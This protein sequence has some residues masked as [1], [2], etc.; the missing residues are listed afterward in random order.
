M[1]TSAAEKKSSETTTP[2]LVKIETPITPVTP[3]VPQSYTKSSDIEISQTFSA[4]AVQP[5]LQSFKST[6]DTV[7]SKSFSSKSESSSFSETKVVGGTKLTTSEYVAPEIP[8]TYY[9]STVENKVTTEIPA[10]NETESLSL[11]LQT[12]TKAE[13]ISSETEATESGIETSSITKQSSLQYFVKKMKGD[14]ESTTKEVI[15]TVP[16]NPEIYKKFEDLSKT[17]DVRVVQEV[18]QKVIHQPTKFYEEAQKPQQFF[19]EFH[20]TPEPPPEICYIPKT[21]TLK[22]EE[23][24]EKI[25]IIEEMKELP[26]SEIPRGGVKILPTPTKVERQ[27]EPPFTAT[28]QDSTTTHKYESSTHEEKRFSETKSSSSYQ[29]TEPVFRP[30]A[31]IAARAFSPK[32]SAEALEMEKLWAAPKSPEVDR[33]ISSISSYSTSEKNVYLEPTSTQSVEYLLKSSSSAY[34]TAKAPPPWEV[35]KVATPSWSVHSTL[36]KKWS[37]YETKTETTRLESS[38]ISEPVPHYIA[39]VSHTSSINEQSYEKSE[40]IDYTSSKREEYTEDR[41]VKPSE[42]IKSWPPARTREEAYKPFTPTLPSLDSLSIRPISVQDITDEIYLEPGPPPEIG[43]AEPPLM[44][45]QSQVEIIEQDL[46]KNLEREPTK[47]LPGAVRTMPPPKERYVPPPLPPKREFQQPP[48]LP[49]KPSKRVEQPKKVVEIPSQPFEPFPALEPFPFQPEPVKPKPLRIGP[50]PV[51][52]KFVKGRFTDSDYESDFESIRIPSKW[53]PSASDTEELPTY[54][55]VPAPKLNAA[56][57]SRSTE[58]EPVPPSKFDQPLQFQG[59]PRPTFSIHDSKELR[60]ESE[61]KVIKQARHFT[62]GHEA[63]RETQQIPLKPGS[64]PVYVQPERKPKPESPKPKPT[65]V[66]DGYMADT[67][68]PFIQQQ[69]KLTKQEYRHEESSSTEYKHLY[70][71]SGSTVSETTQQ[72]LFAPKTHVPQKVFQHRKHTSSGS[73]LNKVCTQP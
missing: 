29:S 14:D 32:P 48:P 55:R 30:K 4:P 60:Q 8:N 33:P 65:T 43:F 57:R 70:Q 25:K 53:K 23:V 51:P 17:T 37:P 63:K 62:K 47:V 64:P 38:N 35:P 11:P 21:D 1:Q 20:L 9:S 7:I 73:S 72:K 45:R 56:I 40:N 6:S 59:P 54:R 19:E 12:Q 66:I 71:S 15:K 44:R 69:R 67:D 58:S 10:A 41:N 18:P 5:L 31:A 2:T 50:P 52:S 39:N 34:E 24:I 61:Q 27:A 46:E 13:E 28:V 16:I 36:E 22:K 49:A 3:S 68:E 26:P 42:I